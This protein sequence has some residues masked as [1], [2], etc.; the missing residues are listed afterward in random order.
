PRARSSTIS[1]RTGTT[2][3]S[4]QPE[5]LLAPGRRLWWLVIGGKLSECSLEVFRLAEIAV[6]RGETYIGDFVEFAQMRDHSFAD[7]LVADFALAEALK[8][9]HDLGYGLLDA[10]RLDVALA[11][12]DFE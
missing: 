6:D 9:L 4:T 10:L 12:R 5:R 8:L 3:A 1:S 7:G 2:S 11:Q